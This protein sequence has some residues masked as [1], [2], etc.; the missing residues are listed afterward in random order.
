MIIIKEEEKEYILK[1]FP[2]IELSYEKMTHNKVYDYDVMVAIPEGINSFIWFHVYKDQNV[3]YLLE[4]NEKKQIHNISIVLSSFVDSLCYGTVFYGTY[5]KYKNSKCFTIEDIF[6]YKGKQIKK[7]ETY[8]NKLTLFQTI[9]DKD[10]SSISLCDSFLIFG[11]PLI[12]FEKKF[13]VLLNDIEVL[14]YK[15][16]LIQFR[17]LYTLQKVIEVMKY[18]K[19]NNNKIT[20]LPLKYAI[21]KIT[22]DLQ[23]DIYHLHVWENGQ[24]LYYDIAYIPDYKTSVF[25]NKL[26]RNIKENQNLDTLEESDDEE[27]FENDKIDKFVYINKTFKMNCLYNSKFKKWTPINVVDKRDKITTLKLLNNC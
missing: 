4:L 8:L 11:L 2:K 16:K 24:V 21:F 14:P 19:S 3:C 20:N 5:F 6:Y 26:F 13:N 12:S 7:E 23:N 1:Q 25:M 15:V 22:P 9:L 27:E 17:K 18:F 10:I